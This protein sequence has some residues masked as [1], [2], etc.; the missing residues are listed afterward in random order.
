MSS[1]LDKFVKLKKRVEEA[2]QEA[3]KAEGAL[4]QVLK[5]LKSEFGCNSLGD[6]EKKLEQ[7][8]KEKKIAKRRFDKAVNVF[9]ES[10]NDESD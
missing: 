2:K 4:A 6:A 8:E 7:L 3:D 10:W 1:N 9:E 5:Q